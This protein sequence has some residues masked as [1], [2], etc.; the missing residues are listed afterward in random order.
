MSRVQKSQK[1]TIKPEATSVS[2]LEQGFSAM[3]GQKKSPIEQD[4]DDGENWAD[5]SNRFGNDDDEQNQISNIK[6]A[7]NSDPGLANKLSQIEDDFDHLILHKAIF[8]NDTRLALSLLKDTNLLKLKDLV[9]RKDKH[10]NTAL[11]LACMLGR[12]KDIISAFLDNHD[13]KWSIDIRNSNRWTP[14]HEACSYGDR[15]I[16]TLMAKQI[17]DDVDD[18]L[19]NKRLS[20]FLEKT[21]NYRLVLKWEF[22]SWVPFVSRVLPSDVCIIHKQGRYLRI[23]TRLLD[24]EGLFRKK[25]DCCLVYYNEKW[26]V[27]NNKLKK[28]QLFET[29][30]V[31]KDLDDKVDEF[32]AMD[33]MDLE[34]KSSEMQLTRSTSGWIWKADKIGK[35]GRF[36]AAIYDFANV[37]LVT[38]KRREHL[39]EEDLKRNK[40]AYKN[41]VH[42]F[43]FGEKPPTSANHSRG[44]H[45]SSDENTANSDDNNG[46]VGE[47]SEQDS[48]ED[49]EETITHRESLPPPPRAKVTWEQ[50]ID[51]EPGHFPTLGREQKLKTTKTAVKAS[52]AMS[53]EFPLTKNE[54]LDL[55]SV[56]PIKMFKRLKEFVEMKLPEGFPV[57]LD[58]PV[59]PAL[60]ARI[61]F[62]DFAFLGEVVDESLFKVPQDYERDTNLLP[63]RFR[64]TDMQNDDGEPANEGDD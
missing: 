59:F 42:A 46:L 61:T 64:G 8:H 39:S 35:V 22:Q 10:G 50:Y 40:S 49:E 28:Y 60:T 2:G 20:N 30:S 31:Y 14:F 23:D 24:F 47:N 63:G 19:H 12:S 13:V 21:R 1:D 15:D 17:K 9:N 4:D 56:V 7:L 34:F 57:R 33:I 27:M 51:A 48:G 5:A 58:I 62:E 44:H 55:L 52:V 45:S 3:E 36:N 41:A 16:I 43:K 37:F 6:S 29:P 25:G 38:R 32:M 26:I 11:H 54:F 53:E 18:A